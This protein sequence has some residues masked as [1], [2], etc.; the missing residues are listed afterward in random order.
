MQRTTIELSDAAGRVLMVGIPAPRLEE[1]AFLTLRRLRPGGVILFARNLDRPQDLGDLVAALRSVLPAPRFLGIDQEGGRVNR[2][3]PWIGPTPSAAALATRGE[4][5]VRALGV[6]TARSLRALGFN[7]DCAPVV[8]LG[9][10]GATGVIGDRSFGSDPESVARL[11]GAFL[12]SLQE[13]GVAGCLKHFPGIREIDVDPHVGL[14]VFRCSAEDLAEC[15]LLPYRRLGSRAAAVMVG[16][17]SYPELDD[18]PGRPATL[19]PPVVRGWL[20]ER[21]GYG[22]LVVTDDLEMGAIVPLDVDGRAAVEAVSAGCDL[23]LYCKDLDRAE[24]AHGALMRAA[25][26]DAAFAERLLTAAGSVRATAARYPSG[27]VDIAAFEAARGEFA[28]LHMSYG[29]SNSLTRPSAS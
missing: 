8:D 12:D 5:A 26:A 29:S 18:T 1:P 20:R 22:G 7:L 27:D 23:L 19:S 21:L 14:P 11:A 28:E 15:D 6:A 13:H 16:H 25:E 4:A 10:P 9:E 17:G 24:R 3:R 2:L